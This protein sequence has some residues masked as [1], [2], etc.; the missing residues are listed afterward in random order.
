MIGVCEVGLEGGEM[1]DEGCLAGI[2]GEPVPLQKSFVG[3]LER[4][5]GHSII[6]WWNAGGISLY[7]QNK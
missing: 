7:L 2:L 6:D 1:G 5:L 4:G 3:G